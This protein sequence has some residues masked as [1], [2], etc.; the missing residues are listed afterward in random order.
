MS[1]IS[2]VNIIAMA[3][4]WLP[5]STAQSYSEPPHTEFGKFVRIV[6]FPGPF[7]RFKQGLQDGM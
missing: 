7:S 1:R 6:P 4:L 3:V 5:Y 2:T